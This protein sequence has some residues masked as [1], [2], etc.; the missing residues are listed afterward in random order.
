MPSR[1]IGYRNSIAH[2]PRRNAPTEVLLAILGA[3]SSLAPSGNASGST[4]RRRGTRVCLGR[5]QGAAV[6]QAL[7]AV[8]FMRSERHRAEEDAG[9][10]ST[11]PPL[12]KDYS[13]QISEVR[14]N[15]I[16]KAQPRERSAQEGPP[17]KLTSPTIELPFASRVV[18]R[19]RSAH[20]SWVSSK[21]QNG[22]PRGG[23]R[24]LQ[25]STCWGGHPPRS[26]LPPRLQTVAEAKRVRVSS[27]SS[28]L[29]IA[30]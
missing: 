12:D 23:R 26:P 24:H 29:R 1:W 18:T 30:A 20:G 22:I 9:F 8:D 5:R 16:G 15:A 7:L 11:T 27:R 3:H 2:D 19:A 25:Q 10:R 6:P 17:A 13:A 14:V 21:E 28:R 4:I